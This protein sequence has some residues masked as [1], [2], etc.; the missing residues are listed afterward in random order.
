LYFIGEAACLAN[1]NGWVCPSEEPR[2]PLQQALE[3]YKAIDLTTCDANQI[4]MNECAQYR[5]MKADD[6]LKQVLI[7]TSPT[8]GGDE[9]YQRFIA[10]QEA[11][12]KYRDLSCDYEYHLYEGGSAAGFFRD[13]CLAAYDRRR[14]QAL[15]RFIFC[16]QDGCGGQ[17]QLYL[18]DAAPT[19]DAQP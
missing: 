8:L 14:A 18:Y 13:E 10:A 9:D 7:D 1:D 4:S 5:F 2:V 16:E 11:W 19:G 6:K 17:R 3:G 12:C 15:R